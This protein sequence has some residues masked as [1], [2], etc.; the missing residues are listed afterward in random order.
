MRGEE[1]EGQRTRRSLTPNGF[2]VRVVLTLPSVRSRCA[3]ES[4]RVG[5]FSHSSDVWMFGVTL[6][7]MFTYCEEPWFGLSGRQVCINPPHLNS[8]PQ[9][10]W[11]ATPPNHSPRVSVNKPRLYFYLLPN[12]DSVACGAGRRAPGEAGGL[13]AGALRHHEEMLG[14]Q[15]HGSTQL[16]PAHHAGGRGL[17]VFIVL[18]YVH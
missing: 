6:W 17:Q 16:L 7:E 11:N 15:P 2:V 5:S 10:L 8:D 14:V 4:L 12:T 13:P 1:R 18:F 9:S 3:P